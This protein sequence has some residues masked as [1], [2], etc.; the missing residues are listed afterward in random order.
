MR[1]IFFLLLTSC[2]TTSYN[3]NGNN[4][5]RNLMVCVFNVIS[6]TLGSRPQKN[7]C[8]ENDFTKKENL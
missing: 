8:E 2:S 5:E 4:L 1:F 7:L 6:T 3:K